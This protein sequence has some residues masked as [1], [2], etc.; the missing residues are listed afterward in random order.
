[1]DGANQGSN[2]E[3][4]GSQIA[5]SPKRMNLQNQLSPQNMHS[6]FRNNANNQDSIQG[7]LAANQM[8]PKA[9]IDFKK[10]QENMGS[11]DLER[12]EHQLSAQR[13]GP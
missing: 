7:L 4:T 8:S 5:Q 13:D 2:G 12:D 9:N 10:R 6:P 3:A 11:P 1:M